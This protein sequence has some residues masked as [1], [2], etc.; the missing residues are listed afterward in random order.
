MEAIALQEKL[1]EQSDPEYDVEPY[2]WVILALHSGLLFNA[3]IAVTAYIFMP[4]LIV[5]SF[6][7]NPYVVNLS[8]LLHLAI[9]APSSV[10]TS[11]MYN[12]LKLDE[13]LRIAATLQIM[14]SLLRMLAF[15]DGNFKWI[16]LG[17]LPMFVSQSMCINS[18]TYTANAWFA[19]NQKATAA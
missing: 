14:G 6:K 12:C 2:R 13:V 19:Q 16:F 10:L 4:K 5:E 15:V 1:S 7:E 11:K 17:Q 9:V 18:V 3:C 8:I